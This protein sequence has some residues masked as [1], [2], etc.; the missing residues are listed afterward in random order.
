MQIL[1]VNKEP[2]I[3]E[4]ECGYRAEKCIPPNTFTFEILGGV[5]GG[6]GFI[7]IVA[8]LIIYR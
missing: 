8:G 3:D 7:G 6:I 4:P 5:L 1:W 2:P